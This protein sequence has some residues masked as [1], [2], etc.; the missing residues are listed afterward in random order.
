MNERKTYPQSSWPADGPSVAPEPPENTA[1]WIKMRQQPC[2][3]DRCHRLG[4]RP[5]IESFRCSLCNQLFC[6]GHRNPEDHE[7]PVLNAKEKKRLDLVHNHERIIEDIL[8]GKKHGLRE[9]EED[10]DANDPK[11]VDGGVIRKGSLPQKINPALERIRI[12]MKCV[13]EESVPTYDRYHVCIAL[14]DDIVRGDTP[15]ISYQPPILPSQRRPGKPGVG[16]I[17]T[18]TS[19]IYVYLDRTK[20]IGWSI[21]FLMRYFK[22]SSTSDLKPKLC[23]ARCA[24]DNELIRFPYHGLVADLLVDG[25]SDLCLVKA[26][27]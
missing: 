12:R 27:G 26:V 14:K 19:D 15:P 25:D 2:S 9:E 17:I 8:K 23:L 22:L 18:P 4:L 6:L 16:K 20:S 3:Y 21:D 13:G 1:N 24:A 10:G 7:C 11:V 5:L